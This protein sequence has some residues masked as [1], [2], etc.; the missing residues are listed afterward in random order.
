MAP[1]SPD[2]CDSLA[3]KCPELSPPTPNN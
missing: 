3:N 1:T 2:S